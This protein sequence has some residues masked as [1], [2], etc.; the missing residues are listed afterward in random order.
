MWKVPV[1]SITS[2]L[3]LLTRHQAEP[4]RGQPRLAH[5]ERP[6]HPSI[7]RHCHSDGRP[8]VNGRL[9]GT[10]ESH[11]IKSQT[12]AMN[13]KRRTSRPVWLNNAEKRIQCG[14]FYKHPAVEQHLSGAELNS[15][16]VA[17]FKT[18]LPSQTEM[19]TML[20]LPI[21]DS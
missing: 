13:P 21:C 20:E 1:S 17:V 15:E 16:E 18:A 8:E 5:T 10:W 7:F 3:L 12:T 14:T 2:A 11:L 4:H 9:K 6:G 19:H